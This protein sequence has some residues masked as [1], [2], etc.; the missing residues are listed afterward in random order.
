MIIAY[1]YKLKMEFKELKYFVH[2][3]H[4]TEC[5]NQNLN[6]IIC[7]FKAFRGKKKKTLI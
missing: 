7:D 6:L 5:Q 4:I 3:Y 1:F 2:H